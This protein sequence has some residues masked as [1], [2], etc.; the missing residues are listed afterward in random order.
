M[1]KIVRID[2]IHHG[3][4]LKC[5]ANGSGVR[6]V[7]WFNGCDLHCKN[8][9]NQEYW[10]FDN[11]QFPDFSDE[12]V[13][14]IISEMSAYPNIYSGLSILGGEPF[15]KPNIDDV[16]KLA[17]IFK[18]ELP[19]KTIWIWSGHT[20]D[21]LKSQDGEY[22]EKIRKVFETCDVLVDGPFIQSKRNITLKFRGSENQHIIDLKTGEVIE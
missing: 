17:I 2:T 14:L 4:R 15:A 11:P 21:W 16:L 20:Y 5:S 13:Q 18:S 19:D 9:H 10:S 1:G 12:H 6:V 3:D 22:G 8:C 7:I